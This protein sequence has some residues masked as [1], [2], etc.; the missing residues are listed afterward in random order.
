VATLVGVFD[1]LIDAGATIIVI[2]HDLDLLAAADHLI[3]M[4]PGGG[5]DGG[6]I[7]ATGTPQDLAHSP[8]SA[9]GPWLAEHLGI[10]QADP[11]V[12]ATW[13]RPRREP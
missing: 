12:S 11:G 10:A 6:Q 1:R 4:G 9:T 5:P 7:L 3:D 13:P 2:D 8:A